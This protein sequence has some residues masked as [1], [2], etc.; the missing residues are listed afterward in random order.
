MI[1]GCG[2]FGP[3][4]L[5]WQDLCMGPLNIVKYYINI[6]AVGLMVYEKKIFFSVFPIISLLELMTPRAWLI[7]DPRDMAGRIYVG[8]HWAY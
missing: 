8:D 5:D 4:G 2:Q 1:L 7:L 6:S 3:Q